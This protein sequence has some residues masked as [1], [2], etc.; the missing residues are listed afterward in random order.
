MSLP[1]LLRDCHRRRCPLWQSFREVCLSLFWD[2]GWWF[3]C[4]CVGDSFFLSVASLS[5]DLGVPAMLAATTP[6]SSGGVMINGHVLR[7]VRSTALR[8]VDVDMLLVVPFKNIE[9]SSSGRVLASSCNLG[10]HLFLPLVRWLPIEGLLHSPVT[11]ITGRR[12]YGLICNFLFIQ[13]C[14]CKS[15]IVNL[16]SYM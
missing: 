16:Y 12:L 1:W 7:L 8:Y 6:M 11:K 5:V 14:L 13:G 15:C 3:T 4:N 9:V 2:S 10:V